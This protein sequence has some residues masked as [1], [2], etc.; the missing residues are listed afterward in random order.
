MESSIHS[1]WFYQCSERL[2]ES[3]KQGKNKRNYNNKN[4]EKQPAKAEE[5]H[6]KEDCP[7][8]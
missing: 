7:L 2:S 1:F 8:F 4:C 5:E 6:I 3:G